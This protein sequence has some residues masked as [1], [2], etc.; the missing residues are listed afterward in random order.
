M[1]S[2]LAAAAQTLSF[3][4]FAALWTTG[5]SLTALL[6]APLGRGGR[7]GQRVQVV[8]ARGILWGARVRV[9]RGGLARLPEGPII[10]MANHRSHLDTVALMWG[11]RER[12]LRWV[13]K[14]ELG[15]I[16]IFGWAM[17]ALG[18]VLIDRANRARAVESLRFVRAALDRGQA[19]VVF[20]E[21]TRSTADQMLPFRKGGFH[22]AV[23]SGCPIVPVAIRGSGA[24]LPKHAIRPRPGTIEIE[25]LEP[26]RGEGAADPSALLREVRGRI[27]DALRARAG[28]PAAGGI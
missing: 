11:F 5:L 27:E 3:A 9:T 23:Q 8:F 26:L 12:H 20:P 16:P 4:L 21:G 17:R 25:A 18:H 24:V 7:R 15:R 13:A 6:L 14:K 19:I 2:S 1:L 22:L 28:E 10:V